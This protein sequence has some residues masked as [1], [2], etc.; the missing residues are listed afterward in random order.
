MERNLPL[1]HKLKTLALHH[2]H[3]DHLCVHGIAHLLN[4]S[5]NNLTLV[6]CTISSTDFHNL[7]IAIATSK[8]KH[9]KIDFVSSTFG[10]NLVR[11]LSLA[12]LLTLSKTLEKVTVKMYSDCYTNDCNVVRL[13]VKAMTHSSVKKLKLELCYYCNVS[14][15]H[16]DRDQVLV[17]YSLQ[18]LL[19]LASDRLLSTS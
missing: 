9:L 11:G 5:L 8:L 2:V 18:F 16:Y 17:S 6:D 14:D 19:N 12:K 7:T 15:I 3:I 4:T 13:L 1:A 10:I